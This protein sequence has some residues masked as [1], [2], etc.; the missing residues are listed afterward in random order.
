MLKFSALPYFFNS[1][2][3]VRTIFHLDAKRTMILRAAALVI[4]SLQKYV[5]GSCV[6]RLVLTAAIASGW[7]QNKIYFRELNYVQ[8][9]HLYQ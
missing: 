3:D 9:C 6:R 5:S 1:G 7:C 4:F 8:W 2:I